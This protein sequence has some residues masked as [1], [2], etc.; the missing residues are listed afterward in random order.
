[1]APYG[2]ADRVLPEC[3]NGLLRDMP[4]AARI[5][6]FD[7]SFAEWVVALTTGKL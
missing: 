6:R 4:R 5:A 2:L 3:V 1:M 7:D